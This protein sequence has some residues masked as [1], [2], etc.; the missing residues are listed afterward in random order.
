MELMRVLFLSDKKSVEKFIDSV[1]EML[2]TAHI[3]TKT[4][5]E[6]LSFNLLDVDDDA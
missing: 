4:Q 2:F 5:K 6:K 1:T 3:G